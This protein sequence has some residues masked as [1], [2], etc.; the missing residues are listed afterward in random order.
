MSKIFVFFKE[1]GSELR[2]VVWPT[3]DDVIS[4]VKVVIVSTIIIAAIL[5]ALDVL[6][7][8][9]MSLIFKA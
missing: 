4:S 3:R 5:G 2:K 7:G 9:G 6:F 1:C 8:A